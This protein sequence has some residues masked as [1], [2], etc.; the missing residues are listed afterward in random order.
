MCVFSPHRP[1]RTRSRFMRHRPSLEPKSQKLRPPVRTARGAEERFDVSEESAPR[2]YGEIAREAVP[3]PDSSYRP[4]MEE[5]TLAG[6]LTGLRVVA[7]W[8]DDRSP[9]E[10]VVREALAESPQLDVSDLR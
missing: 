1:A 7:A 2:G 8:P 6:E 10:A 4:T 3:L 9:S 5:E